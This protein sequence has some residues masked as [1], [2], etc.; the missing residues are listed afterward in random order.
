M[1]YTLSLSSRLE[2]KN[3][4]EESTINALIANASA[5]VTGVVVILGRLICSTSGENERPLRQLFPSS[6]LGAHDKHN[7]CRQPCISFN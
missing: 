6:L 2:C 5:N 7:I 1:S 4:Q 3:K